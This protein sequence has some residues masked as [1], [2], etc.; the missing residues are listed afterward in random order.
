[1]DRIEIIEGMNVVTPLGRPVVVIGVL[2]A[3]EDDP[4]DRVDCQYTDIEA[5]EN[6]QNN[7]VTLR[8]YLLKGK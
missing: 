6:P 1:M 5:D 2:K 8:P 4:F 7:Q 3:S